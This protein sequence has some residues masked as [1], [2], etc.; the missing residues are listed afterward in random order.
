MNVGGVG[1]VGGSGDAVGTAVGAGTTPVD[2]MLVPTTPSTLDS[3]VDD[4]DV[5]LKLSELLALASN[6]N[7]FIQS[8][9]PTASLFL[10]ST[11]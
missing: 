7:R 3:P 1:G 4:E 8:F 2:R 6:L 5:L 9:R 11:S 10:S